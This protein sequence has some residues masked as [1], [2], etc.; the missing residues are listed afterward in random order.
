M[1]RMRTLV[2]FERNCYLY[3]V[4]S[5]SLAMVLDYV[6]GE[7]MTLNLGN[8][9]YVHKVATLL[10]ID[11]I[12]QFCEQVLLGLSWEENTVIE[13]IKEQ[14]DL[15]PA[16]LRFQP[17]SDIVKDGRH[18]LSAK[19]T[20]KQHSLLLPLSLRNLSSTQANIHTQNNISK[21]SVNSAPM[22]LIIENVRTEKNDRSSLSESN[23]ENG[24]GKVLVKQEVFDPD[25][26]DKHYNHSS[27][28]TRLKIEN[29]TESS[30]QIKQESDMSNNVE[31]E[32]EKSN[33]ELNHCSS[34]QKVM[35]QKLKYQ[36]GKISSNAMLNASSVQKVTDTENDKQSALKTQTETVSNEPKKRTL[37]KRKAK[38][39]AKRNMEKIM[40]DV[41][42]SNYEAIVRQ[43][44]E[45][46]IPP[47]SPPQKARR[48]FSIKPV[49]GKIKESVLNNQNSGE[50]KNSD[51]I[52]NTENSTETS[53]K[54]GRNST[55]TSNY[56]HK[57]PICSAAYPSIKSLLIHRNETHSTP[58]FTCHVCS[59]VHD[60]SVELYEHMYAK[61][62]IGHTFSQEIP[63]PECGEFMVLKEM[64]VDHM[65]A[66][67]TVRLYT[68][69]QNSCDYITQD[70]RENEKH[71]AKH[72]RSVSW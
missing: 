53:S 6:Y 10:Q 5:D 55:S 44:D 17:K 61:H 69:P 32:H 20:V 52:S 35:S 8:V 42:D 26:D 25:F 38:S 3:D 48:I 47:E 60:T 62:D 63:C 45:T 49:P 7:P 39:T 72:N 27:D 4:D 11:S 9:L 34:S 64:L 36:K 67:H 29:D 66:E 12:Q 70:S 56:K 13:M 43:T 59:D 50:I 22:N 33:E 31:F 57:C 71:L 40:D 14:M 30:L 58:D 1:F 19:T 37:R 51:L 23:H 16:C 21:D 24:T 65:L 18:Q 68:C 15:K 54:N 28:D 46:Y 41:D 2:G